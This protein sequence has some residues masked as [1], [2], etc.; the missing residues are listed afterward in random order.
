MIKRKGMVI[1]FLLSFNWG[2]AQSL[3]MWTYSICASGD[4]ALSWTAGETFSSLR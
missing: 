4:P 3:N 2:A 1:S